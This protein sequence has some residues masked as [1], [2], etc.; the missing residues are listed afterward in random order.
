MHSLESLATALCV[1]PIP[2]KG[3]TAHQGQKDQ[4]E[5]PA[6]GTA[7]G[8]R[9]TKVPAAVGAINR[10]GTCR[11]LGEDFVGGDIGDV[12]VICRRER[13]KKEMEG[14]RVRKDEREWDGMT[15]NED[16]ITLA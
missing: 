2:D 9:S 11:R 10:V 6:N 8:G 5:E 16:I 1:G 12:M 4:F 7:R 15:H 13:S 14:E 3:N